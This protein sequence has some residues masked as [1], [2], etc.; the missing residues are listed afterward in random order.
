MS[1]DD[2]LQHPDDP[3]IPHLLLDD[4]REKRLVE[5]GLFRL[6][7]IS[8]ARRRKLYYKWLKALDAMKT[9]IQ[10]TRLHSEA[11]P[12]AQ[13]VAFEARMLRLQ[14]L[15]RLAGFLHFSGLGR[16]LDHRAVESARSFA[17]VRAGMAGATAERP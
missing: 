8:K 12:F 1:E 9:E 10:R 16:W 5:L 3:L 15:L 4:G 7:Y 11:V 13:V 14:W 17:L 2:L 6:A